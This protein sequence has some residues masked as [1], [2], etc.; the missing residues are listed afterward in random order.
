M[1]ARMYPAWISRLFIF[2]M[3]MLAFTGMMQMPLAK[4][5]FIVDIP[6]LAWTGDF[7]LV[8]KVHYLF[9]A[10]L[11]FVVGVVVA[12]WVVDW[13]DKLRLT[14]MGT[15]R[16]VILGGIIVSGGFRVYRNMPDVTPD[17]AFVMTIEWIHFGLV[18]VMGGVALA[19]LIKK[20]SAYAVSK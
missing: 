18:M 20:C 1:K 3:T 2:C 13:R 12:N 9:A 6:G 15:A 8:H 14:A 5:Y 4:R 7:F 11:L 16:A 10:L 17:P 19:A